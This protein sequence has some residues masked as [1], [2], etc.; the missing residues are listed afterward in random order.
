MLYRLLRAAW[1]AWPH[2][3]PVCAAPGRAAPK[4]GIYPGPGLPPRGAQHY[5]QLVCRNHHYVRLQAPLSEFVAA[6]Q[7]PHGYGE[8]VSRGQG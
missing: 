4:R 3:C 1:R 6:L 7:E 2:C 8:R 5:K